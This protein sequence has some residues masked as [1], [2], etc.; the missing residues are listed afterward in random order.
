MESTNKDAS[1]AVE[2][3]NTSTNTNAVC[4]NIPVPVAGC[5]SIII[6][7]NFS[8]SNAMDASNAFKIYCQLCIHMYMY[9][10]FSVF[11]SISVKLKNI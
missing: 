3:I 1:S 4:C 5:T 8:V 2:V 6:N 9:Y 7:G 11:K 10:T